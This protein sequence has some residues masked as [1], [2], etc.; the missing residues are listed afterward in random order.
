[1]NV[2]N[3]VLGV[4]IFIVYLLMLNYG[5]QAFYPSPQYNDFCKN[6]PQYYYPG[7]TPVK[8]APEINC[9]VT[10]TQ[11]QYDQCSEEGGS[12]AADTYDANGCA[13]AFKCDMCNKDWVDAQKAHSKVVFVISLIVGMLTLLVGWL[14]L[15][16]EPVGSSLMASGVGAFVY[17]SI[18]NW[19]NLSDIWRFLLLF[20][21]LVL[22][23]WIAYMLNKSGRGFF[24]F[25]GKKN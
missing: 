23:I 25:G 21:A 8:P 12:L 13:A 24:G 17:G 5:I 10:P 2:K 15:T 9:S 7:S 19:N 16:F 18:M 20:V 11:Q 14:F 3:L 6:N 1:M 22:L 4:G